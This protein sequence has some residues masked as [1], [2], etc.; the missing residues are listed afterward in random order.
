MAVDAKDSTR[1]P[2]LQQAR[3]SRDL[4]AIVHYGL[5][6]AGLK[7]MSRQFESHSGDGLAFGFDPSHLPFVI[8]PFADVLNTLLQDHNAGPGPRLR[9]RMSVHV[10]PVPRTPGLPGDGNAAPRSETHRLLDSVPARDWLARSD[11]HATPLVLI[12]SETV[13]RTVVVG[14]YC[15]VPQARFTK[16]RA[17][18]TGKD[19]ARTAWVYVPSPSGELLS[20]P[21]AQV[22]RVLEPRTE[23]AE[24]PPP[25]PRQGEARSQFVEFGVAVMDCT[26]GDLHHHAAL[27]QGMERSP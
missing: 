16:V 19:F 12:V 7:G 6:L 23:S 14:G 27:R 22:A 17:E 15:A 21:G 9:L 3:L 13:Y 8:S 2:S 18:V 4:T 20:G 24:D 11:E 1:L 25:A 10:G 5:E 26:M